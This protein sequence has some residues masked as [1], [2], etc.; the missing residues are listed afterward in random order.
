MAEDFDNAEIAI[1]SYG[2]MSGGVPMLGKTLVWAIAHGMEI[3][4]FHK[5][6]YNYRILLLISWD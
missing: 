3:I 5:K 2:N 4:L 6:K 1:V